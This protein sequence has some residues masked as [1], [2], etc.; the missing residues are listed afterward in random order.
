[1]AGASEVLYSALMIR[2]GFL[3]PTI[4]F[5]AQEEDAPKIHVSGKTLTGEPE[6]VLS[7]SFG[8]GGTNA[9]VVLRRFR[10]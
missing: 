2:D 1:M 6:V 7:N 3:A 5:T 9:C 4:N 8:F 10:Q